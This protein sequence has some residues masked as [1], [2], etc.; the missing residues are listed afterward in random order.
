MQ[1]YDRPNSAYMLFYERSESLEPV[2]QFPAPISAPS[3]GPAETDV[4]SR[5]SAFVQSKDELATPNQ[6]QQVSLPQEGSTGHTQEGSS[7]QSPDVI[8]VQTPADLETAIQRTQ[9]APAEAQDGDL[10]TVPASPMVLQTSP[11]PAATPRKGGP[12]QLSSLSPLKVLPMRVWESAR[13]VIFFFIASGGQA[14]SPM[15]SQCCM[16]VAS[17]QTCVIRLQDRV[18]SH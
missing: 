3:Q 2:D 7:L 9:S 1:E 5:E 16:A 6:S 11:S 17:W 12:A 18:V 13:C 15:T 14:C 10:P 8:M 4:P